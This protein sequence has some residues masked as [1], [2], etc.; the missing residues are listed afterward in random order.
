MS[1][2]KAKELKKNFENESGFEKE[3]RNKT[4]YK[5]LYKK[6]KKKRKCSNE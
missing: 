5:D 2:K 3:D 1:Q 6:Y 4:Y